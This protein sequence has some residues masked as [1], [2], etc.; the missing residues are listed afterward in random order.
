MC[1][2]TDHTYVDRRRCSQQARPPTS[3]VDSTIDFPW[4]N[5]L[6]PE[7]GTKFQGGVPL[8]FTDI[9]ISLKHSV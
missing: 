2:W 4:R 1:V 9:R 6:S 5:C 3:F 7:F 8:F